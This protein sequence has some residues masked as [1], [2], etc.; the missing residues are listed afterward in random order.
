MECSTVSMYVVGQP[1]PN[2]NEEV[3]G[4]V[5]AAEWND[6]KNWSFWIDLLDKTD[7]INYPN[8]WNLFTTQRISVKVKN[9]ETP[10]S[11]VLVSISHNGT[12]LWQTKSD[13]KGKAELFLGPFQETETID[14]STCV[15]NINGIAKGNKLILA[16]QGTVEVNI[17]TENTSN[18]VE[19]AFIVDATGSMGDELAF[20][21]EDLKN[22][23]ERIASDEPDLDIFTST[24]FYRD[25]GDDY[26]TK[27]SDFTQDINSTLSF[28]NQQSA[29]GGGDFEEAVHTALSCAL[30]DLQWSDIACNRIAFLLL[31]APPHYEQ[32]IIQDLQTSVKNYAKKGIKVIPITASGINKET[33]FLMR[34]MAILTNGTYVFITNDSGV[35]NDHLEAS[36]GQYEVEKLNDLLVRLIKDYS[37]H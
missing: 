13:Q 32:D 12:D 2:N 27:H 1:P 11:N 37:K 23:I 16:D 10:V 14:L 36:V 4:T 33:E 7:S 30:N 9:G 22:V 29:N 15:L 24:I 5:T 19:L 6:L 17:N 21:K 18:K 31:D 26:V 3:S 25:E 20:L 8:H 28:I 34:F 35:G